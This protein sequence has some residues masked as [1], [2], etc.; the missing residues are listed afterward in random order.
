M[1]APFARCSSCSTRGEEAVR[2]ALE[3]PSIPHPPMLALEAAVANALAHALADPRIGCIRPIEGVERARE[4]A[5]FR[6][7]DRHIY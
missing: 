2:A 5:R 4:A 6:D 1:C 7:G 3:D